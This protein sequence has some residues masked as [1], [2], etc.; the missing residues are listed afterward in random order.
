M[1]P[2]FLDIVL[3]F[4]PLVLLLGLLWFFLS[5]ALKFWSN[6]TELQKKQTAALERIATALEQRAP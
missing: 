4:V 5:R 2:D 6:Y 1:G 3:A